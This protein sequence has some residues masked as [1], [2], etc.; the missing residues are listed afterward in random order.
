MFPPTFLPKTDI[1]SQMPASA[2]SASSVLIQEHP[3]HASPLLEPP[4]PHPFLPNPNICLIRCVAPQRRRPAATAA[5]RW[6]GWPRAA[7]ASR[8]APAAPRSAS[9]AARPPAGAAARVSAR[10]G[11]VACTRMR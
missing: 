9:V 5:C 11:R 4:P 10:A 2:T 3:A 8:V 6:R 7:A 1:L